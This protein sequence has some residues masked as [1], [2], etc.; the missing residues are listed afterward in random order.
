MRYKFLEVLCGI[1]FGI[2]CF[3]GR[4]PI[5]LNKWIW[6]V[7]L[8]ID[9]YHQDSLA[10]NWDLIMDIRDGIWLH[11][12]TWNAIKALSNKQDSGFELLNSFR[13]KAEVW[14][15]HKQ[16]LDF[17][18]SHRTWSS[19][20]WIILSWSLSDHFVWVVLAYI[21]HDLHPHLNLS[22]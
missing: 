2:V 7:H 13:W 15:W 17:P 3:M 4:N 10:L 19:H 21:G 1:Q 9:F 5:S 14:L 6:N 16:W 11:T 20:K 18:L 12:E 22:P 8:R